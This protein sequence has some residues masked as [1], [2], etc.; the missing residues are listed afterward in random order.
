M[1][2]R[3]TIWILVIMVSVIPFGAFGFYLL[4]ERNVSRLPIYGKVETANG[5]KEY[6]TIPEFKLTNQNEET[7]STNDWKD[8]IVIADF[9]FSHCPVICPKMTKKFTARTGCVSG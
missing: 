6:H 4:Y 3:L 2:E 8:K 5:T 7:I 1:K 9:F